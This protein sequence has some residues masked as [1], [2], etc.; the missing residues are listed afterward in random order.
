MGLPGQGR[1]PTSITVHHN[2]TATVQDA[3]DAWAANENIA[4]DQFFYAMRNGLVV[5]ASEPLTDEPIYLMP[6]LMG[7][8]KRAQDEE[9]ASSSKKCAFPQTILPSLRRL[10]VP[11]KLTC[12]IHVAG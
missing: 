2:K 1:E 9:V 6:M 3:Y 8:G 10:F 4:D 11:T 12:S 5:N 7:A